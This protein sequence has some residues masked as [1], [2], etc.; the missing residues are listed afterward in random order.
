VH[1]LL[2]ALAE[3]A[4]TTWDTGDSYFSPTSFQISNVHAGTGAGNVVPGTCQVLFN[5]RFGPASSAESLMRQ[6]EDVLASHRVEF[7][8]EWKR[9]AHPFLTP[10]KVLAR[11]LASVVE[12]AT[13]VAPRSSTSGG[14]SDGRFLVDI[15]RELVEFGPVNRS[16]HAIDEHIRI[17]DLGPLSEVYRGL[18][19]TLLAS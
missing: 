5:F 16:I 2:P 7:D 6:V 17:A 14:T 13:G 1:S 15:S 19:V 4:A 10:P 3:L 8:I 12:S 18:F 11:T 9:G